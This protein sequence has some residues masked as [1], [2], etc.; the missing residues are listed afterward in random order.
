MTVKITLTGAEDIA[1]RLRALDDKVRN[2]ALRR[3]LR[4][5]AKVIADEVRANAPS[6][7][8]RLRRNIAVTTQIS[9]QKQMA[10]AQV[11]VRTRGKAGDQKN[12]F[13]WRFIEYGTRSIKPNPF[14][15]QA[16]ESEKSQAA[17]QVIDSVMAEIAKA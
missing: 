8:G 11:R 6:D 5:A 10:S 2:R 12:S 17:Q 16:F 7:S 15:T 1:K 9:R 4:A 14:A 13:Y 3:S